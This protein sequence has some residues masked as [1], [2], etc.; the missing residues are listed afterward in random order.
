MAP[1]PTCQTCVRNYLGS[2]EDLALSENP[3]QLAEQVTNQ[4]AKTDNTVPGPNKEPKVNPDKSKDEAAEIQGTQSVEGTDTHK[5]KNKEFLNVMIIGMK[6]PLRANNCPNLQNSINKSVSQ[7]NSMV[8]EGSC[9]KRKTLPSKVDMQDV[10]QCQTMQSCQN[11]PKSPTLKSKKIRHVPGLICFICHEIGHYMRHCPQKPYMDALLQANMSTSR[12]PFYP[13]GSPN[14]QNVNAVRP[15]FPDD[16]RAKA[17]CDMCQD[18]QEKKKMQEYKRR[19][20]MSLGIQ[21]K[22]GL[23]RKTNSPT[24]YYQKASQHS[25][26]SGSTSLSTMSEPGQQATMINSNSHEGS[27]SVPCPT[28]SK[29]RGHKAGVECF[30]CHEMGHYS[31]DC[32]QKAKMKCPQKVKSKQVQ[33]TTSLPNVS[34]PK[35]SKPPNSGSASLTS[36]PVGQGRLNHVQVETNGKVVNLEQVERAGEEQ[37]PQARAE[38]Q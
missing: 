27:N 34:G 36:P 37:V 28:P 12:M 15:T 4:V 2:K 26:G 16:K 35:S 3:N 10:P 38:P 25:N 23:C 17:S 30:T 19:K 13:Q 31:W 5:E 14:L 8:K 22:E 21:A 9:H 32:P 7:E 6:T 1:Q 18:I 11:L 24:Q 29:R 33:Q 20:V